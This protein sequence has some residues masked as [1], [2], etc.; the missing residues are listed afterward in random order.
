MPFDIDLEL[1]PTDFQIKFIELKNDLDL[2]AKFL[3]KSFLHFYKVSS[4]NKISKDS[5]R[6]LKMNLFV[7]K[8]FIFASNCFFQ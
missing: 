5:K 4:R 1:L 8:Y 7:W 2:K 6:C 3:S